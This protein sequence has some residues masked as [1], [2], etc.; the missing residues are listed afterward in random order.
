MSVKSKATLNTVAYSTAPAILTPLQ[1]GTLELPNRVVMSP[2]TRAR[3]TRGVPTPLEA[4]YYSQ[5]ASAGLIITGGIYISQQAVGAINVP[6][7]YTEEQVESW[8]QITEA[9]HSAGGR[10]FAQLSHSGS[11]SHPS[12]LN[13][14]TPV[15]PSLVNPRQKVLTEEGY[16]DTIEPRVLTIVEIKSV[17]KDYKAAAAN[18]K[19]AGFDGVEVHGA[20]IYLLPQFLSASTNQRQ[21]AYGGSPENRARIVLEILT[22]IGSVWDH[23]RIGIKLSPAI[24][25]IGTYTATDYILEWLSGFGPAYLHL[26][27]GFDT[28]GNPTELLREHTFDHFRELFKGALIG[29]G[30]FDLAT[31]N[32]HVERGN[33]DL[34]SFARHFISNPDLVSR[35]REN[36]ALASSD[37]ATYYTGGPKGYIDYPPAENALITEQA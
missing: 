18:A 28:N 5:R 36:Q 16:V 32:A 3:S 31:A 24:S 13:G 11:V 30:G 35:F 14:Q 20:N 21:D 17:V 12:L 29:N 37:P 10:I 19:N 22:A 34:V 23:N 33:V 7:I 1:L 9:V 27:R 4:Q 6:G 25:G 8:R 15:A 2:M 26:R